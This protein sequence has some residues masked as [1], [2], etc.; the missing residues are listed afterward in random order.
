MKKAFL[1]FT[2]LPSLLLSVL[3]FSLVTDFTTKAMADP[4]GEIRVVES[5]RP[6]VNVLAHNVLQYLFEYA[7]DKNELAPSLGISRWNDH[8]TLEI[9]LRCP[10]STR[11][12]EEPQV[13]LRAIQRY[14][15]F[16]RCSGFPHVWR[17]L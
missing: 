9:K 2:V 13:S 4:H 3:T 1:V 6:D 5:W 17:R 10:N 16:S 11:H 8:T 14:H 15:S 7:L 12:K